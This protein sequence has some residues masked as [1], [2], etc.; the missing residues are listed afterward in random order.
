MHSTLKK[1]YSNLPL[2]PGKTL[3][4]LKT[5]EEIS[6]RREDLEKYLKVKYFF[7]RFL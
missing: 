3:F 6:K 1:T 2:L 5:E 4:P 7:K